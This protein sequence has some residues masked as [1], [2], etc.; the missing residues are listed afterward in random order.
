MNF[1]TPPPMPGKVLICS[2]EKMIPGVVSSEMVS[3]YCEPKAGV[4]R[5]WYKEKTIIRRD[6]VVIW[7]S[8]YVFSWRARFRIW[9]PGFDPCRLRLLSSSELSSAELPFPSFSP[10]L[11]SY[12]P[13]ARVSLPFLSG[14]R[15]TSTNQIPLRNLLCSLLPGRPVWLLLS[16]KHANEQLWSY[17][18]CR[19]YLLPL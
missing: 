17:C 12:G 14:T 9:R 8:R 3:A 11:I 5:I 16:F 13:Q 1:L 7:M 15:P 6:S 2:Y 19:T 10:S 4:E 18:G